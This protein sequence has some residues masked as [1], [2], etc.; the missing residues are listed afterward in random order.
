M[1]LSLVQIIC[2]ELLC[3][4]KGIYQERMR[5]LACFLLDSCCLSTEGC[6]YEE[7]ARCQEVHFA[8]PKLEGGVQKQTFIT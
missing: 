1:S 6:L 2:E 8:M 7:R 3:S 4:G 5:E